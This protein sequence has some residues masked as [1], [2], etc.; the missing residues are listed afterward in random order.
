MVGNGSSDSPGSRLIDNLITK[1]GHKMARVATKYDNHKVLGP[2]QTNDNGTMRVVTADGLTHEVQSVV[3]SDKD[4]QA[5][6]EYSIPV[7]SLAE[8]NENPL[9]SVLALFG[10][11]QEKLANAA[12][13]H[14]NDTLSRKAKAKAIEASI[15]PEKAL[16]KTLTS[17]A[18]R[19]K[20]DEKEFIAKAKANPD[21]VAAFMTLA[22]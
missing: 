7:Y 14:Y 3:G 12:L 1:E 6:A 20:V 10:G 15:G 22:E 21:V 16:I 9:A 17:I 4:S 2:F 19:L 13:A 18:R 8:G 5:S 11:S